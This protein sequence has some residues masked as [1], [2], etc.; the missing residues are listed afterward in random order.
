[1]GTKV[2]DLA[3]ETAPVL[4]DYAINERVGGP[5]I[6]PKRTLWQ[7]VFNLFVASGMGQIT[8]QDGISAAGT[9]Q[10]T[11]TT[12]TKTHNR[13]DTVGANSGV[14][15]DSTDPV[16]RTVQNNGANDLKWYP[17]STNQFYIPGSGLQ[18][19]GIP[20]TI[21]AGNSAK[22]IR[23]STGVLTIQF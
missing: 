18:G 6:Q 16:T 14:V 13:I 1:M 10:G 23:Y 7:T 12:I 2:K 8:V 19:A 15:E 17:Y 22:Y 11:A 3:I 5:G 9:T 21:A 20:I 4:T